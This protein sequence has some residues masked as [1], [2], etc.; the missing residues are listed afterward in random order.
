MN[1]YSYK[2]LNYGFIILATYE[3]L[4]CIKSTIR[5]L[6][7]NYKNIPYICVTDSSIKKIDLTE[8]AALCP[9]YKAKK[10][11]SSL[12]NKGMKETK[13]FWNIFLCAGVTVTK[14]IYDRLSFFVESEDEVLYPV[15]TKNYSFDK[16]SLNGMFINKKVWEKI[17]PMDDEGEFDE[18][19]A[20]WC[21]N[22]LE[23]GIKFKG[24]NGIKIC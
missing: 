17:G 1:L 22:G 5:C 24:I 16:A 19:K 20:F 11:Y 10:T 3:N 7:N 12:I 15:F 2:K 21:F 4:S 18:I 6:K 13:C 8:V 23:N 9:V 14:G